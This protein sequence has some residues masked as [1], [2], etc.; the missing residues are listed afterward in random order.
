MELVNPGGLTHHA[1]LLDDASPRESQPPLTPTSAPPT[2]HVPLL[3]DD[4]PGML[5]L[6]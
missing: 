4:V 5:L 6:A 3:D 1:P 2:H